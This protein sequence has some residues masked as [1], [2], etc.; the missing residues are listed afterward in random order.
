MLSSHGPKWCI[1]GSDSSPRRIPAHRNAAEV[2]TGRARLRQ[3]HRLG[4]LS[5]KLVFKISWHWG[6][7]GLSFLPTLH[8][9]HRWCKRPLLLPPPARR[10][11]HTH[12]TWVAQKPRR[13]LVPRGWVHLPLGQRRIRSREVIPE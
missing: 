12:G 11:W 8:K 4:A 13:C 7:C 1:P 9:D 5:A 2:G 6:S 3:R 10:L